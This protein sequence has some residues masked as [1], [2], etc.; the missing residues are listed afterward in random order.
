[1]WFTFVSITGGKVHKVG[2]S[3]VYGQKYAGGDRI[4]VQLDFNKRTIEFFK[5]DQSQVSE[6][7]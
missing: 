7:C 4:S 6:Q 3:V 2:K 5:N 1:M